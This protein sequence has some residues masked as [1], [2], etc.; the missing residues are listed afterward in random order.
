MLPSDGGPFLRMNQGYGTK[1]GGWLRQGGP[2]KL[3]IGREKDYVLAIV[4]RDFPVVPDTP[5]DQVETGIPPLLEECAPVL[6]PLLMEVM[7]ASLTWNGRGKEDELCRARQEIDKGLRALPGRCSVTSSERARSKD[8]SRC[9]KV[10]RFFRRKFSGGIWSRA[11]LP[12]PPSIPRIEETPRSLRT[13]S[14]VPTPQPKSTA[15]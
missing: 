6:E 12:K 5:A 13:D 4:D 10:A 9:V 3:G 7:D 1:I 15:E 11:W 2:G 8:C 14:Q